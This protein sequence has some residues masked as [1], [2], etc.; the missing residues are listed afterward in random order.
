MRIN[1]T[2][3]TLAG[4]VALFSMP[5][6]GTAAPLSPQQALSRVESSS[7]IHRMP[8]NQ[9]FVLA[10]TEKANGENYLYVFNRGNSGFIVASADDRMPPVL[11]YSSDGI[12]DQANAS[13][14]LKWWLEQYAAQANSH[15]NS[16]STLLKV[17]SSS[18]SQHANVPELMQT[19]WDQTEP[20][21]LDCPMGEGYNCVTGC[22]ATAMAQVMKYHGYPATGSGQHSYTWHGQTLSYDYDAAYFDYDNMLDE[23]DYYSPATEAQQQAVANIMYAC[24][25]AVNMDYSTGASSAYDYMVPYALT[26]YFNYDKGIRYLSR[27]CY[28]AEEWDNIVYEEVAAGRPVIYGGQSDEGGHSFVCD[29]YE[30]GF[31]HINWGWSGYGNGWFLLSA[32]DPG[33]QGAGGF[34][35]GYNYNQDIICGIQPDAG[36]P[37]TTYPIIATGGLEVRNVYYNSEIYLAFSGGLILSYSPVAIPTSLYLKAV[38]ADGEE[39]IGEGMQ[40]TF[41]ASVGSQIYGFSA[42]TIGLPAVGQ[43]SYTVYL[44]YMGPQGD[45][46]PVQIPVT[47]ADH[48]DMNVDAEGNVTFGQVTP[49]QQPQIKVTQLE[50]VSEV[51]SGAETSF[52]ISIENIGEYPYSGNIYIRTYIPGAE[53]A[54]TEIGIGGLNISPGGTLSGTVG[55]VYYLSDGEYV[56][57][58]YDMYGEAC[59]E[60]FQLVIGHQTIDA[61]GITLDITEKTITEGDSFTIKAT[62]EPENTTDKTVT[63][64][65]SDPAV[66]TVENGVVTA[67]TP[68]SATITATTANGLKATCAV[69]V[70]AKV[71]DATGISLDITEKTLTEGDSFTLT[72]TISPENSTDKTVTWS[73]S[74]VAVAKV[75]NGVVTAVAPGTATITA[76]TTNGLTATCAVTVEKKIIL[77]TSITL[78][79]ETIEAPIGTTVKLVA[80][81]LPDNTTDKTVAWSSSDTSIATV[82]EE[83][84]VTIV[85]NGTATIT[86]STTDGSDLNAVCTVYGMTSLQALMKETGPVDIY[87]VSGMLIRKG[88]DASYFETLAKGIYV[89]RTATSTYKIMK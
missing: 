3:K 75:E 58:C 82:D 40:L 18:Q 29:G 20:Y 77:A 55:L 54:L 43:G 16:G 89:I 15:L 53:E 8:G 12:F 79:Q 76:T 22:V 45:L 13:P 56:Q 51:I 32:L 30:D 87:T 52:R 4:A 60:D 23:Y 19:R 66:A 7:T 33:L 21:C 88:A 2:I 6:C 34:E 78:D 73:T 14:E 85:A 5:L 17:V 11:G 63:W 84:N 10:H 61:A 26:E 9:S 37:Q 36:N 57:R 42:F 59:S 62:I 67:V 65:S 49:E 47:G 50:P 83:G 44:M 39:T 41:P 70:K 31:F 86:A 81:V 64:S 25:V 1:S 35:G 74:D 38:S 24:G 46:Q 68:G 69:T 48:L 27:D 28:S 71:I 72:A 80:T